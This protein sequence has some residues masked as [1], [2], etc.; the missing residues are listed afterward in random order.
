L[1]QDLEGILA[2]FCTSV[3]GLWKIWN[4]GVDWN[5][6]TEKVGDEVEGGEESEEVEDEETQDRGNS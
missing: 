2:S 3:R 6:E 4:V 1:I 5:E